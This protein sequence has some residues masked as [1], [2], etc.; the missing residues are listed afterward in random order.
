MIRCDVMWC[1]VALRYIT[2]HCVVSRY[3]TSRHVTSRYAIIANN[4]WCYPQG[5]GTYYESNYDV[6]LFMNN[7]DAISGHHRLPSRLT[8]SL[9][10]V[11][12]TP[13]FCLVLLIFGHVVLVPEKLS[14]GIPEPPPVPCLCCFCRCYS[15]SSGDGCSCGSP[16]ATSV[17]SR[18]AG[19]SS[20]AGKL[21]VLWRCFVIP[22][23]SLPFDSAPRF[24]FGFVA[25]VFA[26]FW[27]YLC[28]VAVIVVWF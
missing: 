18:T 15:W 23:L 4:C 11:R 28:M 8:R 27:Q 6:S 24:A 1:Y 3:V 16:E 9:A 7:L 5:G 14:V 13:V 19:A 17:A 21:G 10:L 20:E 2:S 26:S 12:N 25:F 22:Q